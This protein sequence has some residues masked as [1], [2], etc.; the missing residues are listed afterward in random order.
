M[1]NEFR[2][3]RESF[4]AFQGADAAEE[5]PTTVDTYVF[6]TGNHVMLEGGRLDG[7]VVLWN[8]DAESLAAAEEMGKEFDSFTIEIRRTIPWWRARWLRL[9]GRGDRVGRV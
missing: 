8:P 7:G 6:P 5:W 1:T 3:F 4:A 2:L 9:A